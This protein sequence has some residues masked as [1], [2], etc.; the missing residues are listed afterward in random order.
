M[1]RSVKLYN[2]KQWLELHNYILMLFPDIKSSKTTWFWSLYFEEISLERTFINSSLGYSEVLL[3]FYWSN[4]VGNFLS[5]HWQKTW[6]QNIL[7]M[8][9]SEVCFLHKSTY[10]SANL[11]KCTEI[12]VSIFQVHVSCQYL[13]KPR[14]LMYCACWLNI[15]WWW[16]A[17]PVQE[18]ITNNHYSTH[19]VD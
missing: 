1:A 5:Y 11:Q 8:Q 3:C 14:I 13:H 6:F 10:W 16:G 17:V 2:T 9:N 12:I 4:N 18:S 19:K 7:F 15:K